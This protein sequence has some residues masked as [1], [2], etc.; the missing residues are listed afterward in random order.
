RRSRSGDRSPGGSDCHSHPPAVGS[1]KGEASRGG[2]RQPRGPCVRFWRRDG[3]SCGEPGRRRARVRLQRGPRVAPASRVRPVGG[4]REIRERE[5]EMKSKRFKRLLIVGGPV[6]LVVLGIAVAAAVAGST[7]SPRDQ[8][9]E[10]S[11]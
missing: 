7:A 9:P 10:I 3:S 4:R 2:G 11:P 6:S 5:G 8:G 1:A